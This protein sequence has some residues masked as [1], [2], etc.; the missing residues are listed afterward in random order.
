M[1]TMSTMPSMTCWTRFTDA[2]W[3]CRRANVIISD[4]G[5]FNASARTAVSRHDRG[6]IRPEQPNYGRT[7]NLVW[8]LGGTA[9]PKRG[10]RRTSAQPGVWLTLRVEVT[11]RPCRTDGALPRRSPSRTSGVHT[12]CS[13][14]S[15]EHTVAPS[16]G[17]VPHVVN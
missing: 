11:S 12:T 13:A 4:V 7:D 15:V 17:S 3:R 1:S 6:C 10:G 14:F 5:E 16:L 9:P 8:Y 2:R